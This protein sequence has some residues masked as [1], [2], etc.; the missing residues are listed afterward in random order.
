MAHG[1][2]CRS[3]RQPPGAEGDEAGAKVSAAWRGLPNW[4]PWPC[5]FWLRRGSCARCGVAAAGRW[6]PEG[7][8]GEPGPPGGCGHRVHS[9]R[10]RGRARAV[11]TGEAALRQRG[12]LLPCVQ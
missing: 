11:M 2:A 6:A 4:D 3:E 7:P 12:R 10:P 9:Q 5:V 1:A 8:G